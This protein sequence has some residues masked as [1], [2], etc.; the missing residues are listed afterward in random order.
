MYNV[1]YPKKSH[2]I[3][4]LYEPWCYILSLIHRSMIEMTREDFSVSNIDIVDTK[5]KIPNKLLYQRTSFLME[6][7]LQNSRM[8]DANI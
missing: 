3:V 6:P 4:A 2:K 7:Q 8:Q 5:K 1:V